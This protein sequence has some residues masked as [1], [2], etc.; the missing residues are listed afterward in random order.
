MRRLFFFAGYPVIFIIGIIIGST[1]APH[2]TSE[3]AIMPPQPIMHKVLGKNYTFSIKNDKAEE[4]AKIS[5]TIESADTQK[6]III[7]G[8][9]GSAVKGKAF[10]ILNLKLTNPSDKEISIN[11]RDYVRL[12]NKNADLIASDIHN[13]PVTIQPISTKY[14][15][16]G[17]T[18]DATNTLFTLQVGEIDG[19]KEKIPLHI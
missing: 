8:Q 1:L 2:P 11:T 12:S 19:T 13:D 15:R 16:L 18:I 7:K 4:V 17:F 6:D 5:Y 3:T 14:T 10:L 9:K